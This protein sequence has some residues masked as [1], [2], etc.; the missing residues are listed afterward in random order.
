MASITHADMRA[1]SGRLTL[2][3]VNA[4]TLV[5]GTAA[6][7]AYTVTDCW[8][9]AIGGAAGVNDSVDI[10]DSVSGTIVVAFTRAGLTE[11]A[12]LRSGTATTGVGTN[13]GVKLGTGEGI[14]VKN[15]GGAC[16][17]MTHLDYVILYK[18]EAVD[19]T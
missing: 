10:V 15:T 18:V 2:A 17:T 8:V 16:T 7:R 19:Q 6:K 4:G 1:A 3:Q 13:L 12:V 11:N 9:R 5:V 14:K